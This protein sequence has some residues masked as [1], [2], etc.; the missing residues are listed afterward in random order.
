MLFVLRT[1]HLLTGVMPIHMV[2]VFRDNFC[3]WLVT[4]LGLEVAVCSLPSGC[5]VL[6]ECWFVKVSLYVYMHKILN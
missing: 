5:C 6:C 2:I 3:N 4:V 1:Q